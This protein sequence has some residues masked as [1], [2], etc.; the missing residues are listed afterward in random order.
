MKPSSI[1]APWLRSRP[2]SGTRYTATMIPSAIVG[3]AAGRQPGPTGLI[4]RAHEG[5]TIPA[6]PGEP[7]AA[8]GPG[9]ARQRVYPRRVPVATEVGSSAG[10]ASEPAP[11][12]SSTRELVPGGGWVVGALWALLAIPFV[13]ALVALAHPHWFPVLDMAQTELRIRDVWSAH[14]PLIGLPGRIGTI[15]RQGSHPGPISFWLL[16]PFYRLF[17]ATAWA[18]DAAAVCLNVVVIGATLWLARR[19]GGVLLALGF[20]AVSLLAALVLRLDG[21][22]PGVE[23]VH[24]G[25]LVVAVRARGVVG[26]VRRLGA[27]ARRRARRD[28]LRADPH[29]L[30]RARRWARGAGGRVDG[31]HGVAGP[32]GTAA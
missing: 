28:V 31:G 20:A 4:G 13:V 6:G 26:P 12:V 2:R 21:A 15:A 27:A 5:A 18:M 19:R 8:G 25:P 9:N 17:G 14:P 23:P 30:R 16:S 32:G 24:A 10:G 1:G 3:T 11:D 7:R 22:H 29:L